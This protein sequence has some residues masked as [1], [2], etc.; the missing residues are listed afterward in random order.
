M[1]RIGGWL[2]PLFVL[3]LFALITALLPIAPGVAQSTPEKHEEI[4]YSGDIFNSQGYSG[5]FFPQGEATIFVIADTPNVLVPINTLVYWWPISQEYKADWETLYEPLTGTLEIGDQ[6]FETTQYS[7]KYSGG[8]DSARTSLLFG[9]DA[10]QQHA[11]YLQAIAEYNAAAR[12]YVIDRTNFE[13]ELVEWGRAVDEARAKDAPTD[14]I[15]VPKQPTPP[16]QPTIIV[17]EPTQGIAFQMPE[18]EFQMRLRDEAGAIVP[19]SERRL[20]AFSP[21]REGI[22]YNVIAASKYTVPETSTDPNDTIFVSGDQAL[23]I[24]PA[25]EKEYDNY[26]AAKLMNSQERSV[27]D[28]RGVWAWLPSGEFSGNELTMAVDSSAP[29]TLEKQTWYVK[30]APGAALGY[31]ILP[32]DASVVGQTTTFDAF[33][34]IPESGVIKIAA[35]GHS[36]SAREIRVVRTASSNLLLAVALLPLAGGAA[37]LGYR[38][39]RTR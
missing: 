14:M 23:Y 27:Q 15:P 37:W 1:A 39:W 5:Q 13:T 17:T 19:G 11:A 7:L 21:R 12:D 3:P 30:Q 38:R 10:A 8:Y 6:Q 4:V 18:G 29:Q 31:E 34:I 35:P 26:Y 9:D 24:Q 28:R 22:A 32:Y 36:G 2:R 33:Q 16:T 25:L 20:V